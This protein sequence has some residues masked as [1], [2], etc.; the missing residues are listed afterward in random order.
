MGRL[1]KRRQDGTIVKLALTESSDNICR[2]GIK[3]FASK[4]FECLYPSAS[5]T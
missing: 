3:G 4:N 2:G 1:T 5:V